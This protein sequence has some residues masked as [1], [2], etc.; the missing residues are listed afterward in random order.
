MVH[1]GINPN[2]EEI[3]RKTARAV[4]DYLL[5]HPN[6]R[7]QQLTAIKGRL[8]KEFGFINVIK[9]SIIA[10]Y[11]TSEE[12]S[13]I[14]YLLRRRLTRTLS[15]VTIVAVMTAPTPA[16]SKSCPGECIF[17][18]GSDSQPDV[19]VAQ[20][21][22][23]REPAAMRSAMYHYDPY[24]QT[25][26]RLE[27]LA[28]IGH[29]PDKIELI[30]MG[31]TFLYFPPSY[32]EEFV[33]GCYDAVINFRELNYND[34]KR[35]PSL[36][37]AIQKLETAKT[38]LIGLTFETRPD[39]CFEVHV[40]RML[41]LGATRVE[42]GIQ[43]TREDLL[44]FSRRNHTVADNKRAIQV[45]KDAGLK[46]NAHMMPNLPLS[47]PE[48]DIKVFRELFHDP[49]FRPDMLKIYP[50]LVVVGTELHKMYTS[51]EF[52]PYSQEEIIRVVAQVKTE[53]PSYVRIQR[54]QR[55][56]PVDLIEA[57][58]KNS[59]LRQIVQARLLEEGK[60]CNCIRCREEGFYAHQRS[61]TREPVDLSAVTY[62][63]FT[64]AASG[65]EEHFLSFEDHEK[66][67]LI[68]YLRLR[69]PSPKAH[70]PEMSDRPVAIVREIRVVGEIVGH[71][72]T[73]HQGQIQ[74]R[75]YGKDLMQNAE[76]IARL[77]GCT[78]ILVI[79]GIGARPY[80]YK[81]GYSVD[82][83]YVSKKL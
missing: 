33:K 28:A 16:N 81:L 14:S 42:I 35:T 48:T 34:G 45:A 40:D 10:T 54:I 43:S 15:G 77:K 82:G 12:L 70:R 57:G 65:G 2:S 59:N 78:K 80:F 64:Y 29:H 67:M 73:P 27:D 25:L 69:F 31:G 55:D 66:R 4:I 62:E 71:D 75:G 32:Q 7:K 47:S 63:D 5:D 39:Y 21:Y 74:H 52:A 37:V 23:G 38:R 8:G 3:T 49:E 20:S 79:A 61:Q 9:D 11:T 24:E 1:K 17:C 19:K 6:I 58:V 50:C 56:I 36:H 76:K 18:P 53:L 51:G 72:S 46:V 13:Q 68:G 44:S 22:T 26:H 60:V 41:E 30:I 83:A